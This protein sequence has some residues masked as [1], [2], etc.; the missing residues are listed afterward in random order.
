MLSALICAVLFA[1]PALA[2]A[3]EVRL[4]GDG[5]LEGATPSRDTLL[6][7]ALPSGTDSAVEAAI[8]SANHFINARAD[9][10]GDGFDT[11][12]VALWFKP[13][14]WIA[15]QDHWRMLVNWRAVINAQSG[16][17][18]SF[19]VR[20]DPAGGVVLMIGNFE[21]DLFDLLSI[22][23]EYLA[24]DAWSHVAFVWGPDDIVGYANGVE[25]TRKPRKTGLENHVWSPDFTLGGGHWSGIDQ[26][27]T[28]VADLRVSSEMMSADEV[29]KVYAEHR[30]LLAP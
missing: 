28:A 14:D 1:A 13:L 4:A 22:T 16:A 10:V 5:V 3:V 27:R 8:F 24:E 11:G 2:G 20:G 18:G 29:S 25:V 12:S 23:P 30:A 21:D 19:T 9:E 15:E 17:T 6:T 7:E 26:G